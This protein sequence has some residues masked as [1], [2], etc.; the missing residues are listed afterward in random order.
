LD[1]IAT[2][3]T[4]L[5]KNP[6]SPFTT[7]ANTNLKQLQFF[8]YQDITKDVKNLAKQYVV[9][10]RKFFA[11]CGFDDDNKGIELSAVK[12]HILYTATNDYSKQVPHTDYPLTA[13]TKT[14][15]KNGWIGWT[16]QMPLTTDGCWL[17]V[18]YGPGGS[19]AIKIEF[20]QC[21]FLRGDVV[22]A[23]GRPM[24]DSVRSFYP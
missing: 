17:H 3:V 18:W 23:G 10:F 7:I 5:L 24:V 15:N 20:G 16:A 13:I 4:K 6:N 11:D 14:K 2:S 1:Q 22:H 9:Q 19:T 12:A 21:L 8:G